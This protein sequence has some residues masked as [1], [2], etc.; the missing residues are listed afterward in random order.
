LGRS[1]F[2]IREILNFLPRYVPTAA[3][4]S[5]IEKLEERK[6]IIIIGEPGIGKTVLAEQLALHYLTQGFQI[7]VLSKNISEA[8]AIFDEEK[9]QFFYFDDFLGRNFLEAFGHHEDSEIVA[10]F[11]R[12]A[13]TPNKRFVLTSRTTILNQGKQLSELFRIKNL[14]QAEFELR[15]GALSTIEKAKNPL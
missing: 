7:G 13:R 15:I 9:K 14:D 2:E 1:Q 6:S 12:V 8:E 11:R 10:F 5:A 4:N 3:H